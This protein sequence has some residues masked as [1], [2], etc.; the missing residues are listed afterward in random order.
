MGSKH[1]SY[2]RNCAANCGVV[3]DVEEG[4]ILSVL[5]DRENPISEGY[6]CIKGTVASDLHNGDEDR[7][8]QCMKRD[9]EGKFHPI[10]KYQAI[11]EIADRLSAIVAKNGPRS[12]AVFFGTTSYFDCVGKPFVKSLMSE[13]GS[14]VIF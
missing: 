13:I 12:L 11:D 8:V 3:L 4:R 2:C 6:V 9:E 5:P 10:D 14:P 7:L 1:I